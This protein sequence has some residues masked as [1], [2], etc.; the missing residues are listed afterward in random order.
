MQAA[1]TVLTVHCDLSWIW[2]VSFCLRGYTP[3][4]ELCAVRSTWVLDDVVN[5]ALGMIVEDP[6]C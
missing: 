1:D 2:T 3:A 6:A 5:E 4:A